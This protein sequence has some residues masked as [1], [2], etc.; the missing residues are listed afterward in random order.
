MKFARSLLASTLA[1]GLVV[2]SLLAVILLVVG[3]P[4]A[5]QAKDKEK[6]PEGQ[7]VDSGS[8][9]V[10]MNGRRVGT[11]TFAIYQNAN[12][13]VTQSEFKTEGTDAPAAQR[14]EMQL[15]ASGQ[16]RRYE[17]KEL[18]P[19]K[20]ESVVLPNEQFLTQRWTAT[21]N[22]KPVE[23][24]FLLPL[25]TSILDDYF[26]VH[27][28][29]LAW[30]YLASACK[31]EKGLQCPMKQRVQFG[32]LNPRQRASAPISMECLGGE[33]VTVHG[34]EREMIKLEL[35]SESGNWGLWLE[36][37]FPFKVVRISIPGENT[38]V[39]RD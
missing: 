7:K 9:G 20:A 18:S 32:T 27:R 14:S 31:Q 19:G 13:S 6:E 12:G 30:R 10:F 3:S 34:S 35:K 29:V 39:M 37:E 21:P 5:L 38:E 33:K 8:F 2:I 17:W 23:Q 36:S 16:I 25:S 11:E 1:P 22:E 24:A 28:E 15:T 26:F 4:L